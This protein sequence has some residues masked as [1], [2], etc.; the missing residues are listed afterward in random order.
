ML[1]SPQILLKEIFYDLL[2]LQCDITTQQ[3]SMRNIALKIVGRHNK[4]ILWCDM[5]P[6]MFLQNTLQT[7]H[8]ST[9]LVA[10]TAQREKMING[11]WLYM[12][13]EG[14]WGNPKI[15]RTREG[16]RNF[17][18]GWRSLVK[19]FK[20]GENLNFSPLSGKILGWRSPPL[21]PL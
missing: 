15:T 9:P 11:F 7:S 12:V 14:C 3:V 10:S 16:V 21:P 17:I 4:L 2:W 20:N 8:K 1:K 18:L 5:A 6:T 19:I 13:I